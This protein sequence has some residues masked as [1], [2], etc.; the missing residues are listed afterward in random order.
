VHDGFAILK[1]SPA[2][3][4]AM[5]ETLQALSQIEFE[6]IPEAKASH[7]MDVMEQVMLRDR[8]NWEHHYAGDEEATRLL[9]RYSYSDRIRY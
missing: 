1:V 7:L 4:F 3:T 6:L 5:R 9:R 8:R 2:L